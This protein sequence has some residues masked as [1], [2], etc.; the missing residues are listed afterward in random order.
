MKRIPYCFFY[1]V[2][3]LLISH[4][5]FAQDTVQVV[6]DWLRKN[7]LTIKYIEAGNNFS[8]LQSLKKTL[9]G[10]SVVGLGEATHGTREFFTMKHRLVEFLVKEMGFTAFALESSYSACQ[11]I[12]DYIL[13]GKGD[14]AKALTNQGYMPW[15]TEEFLAMLDWMRAYNQK[16]SDEEKVKF[17]GMDVLC[18]NGVGREKVRAYLAKYAPNRVAATDSLFHVLASEDEKWPSRLNQNALQSTFIPLH[19]LVGYFTA[20]KNKLVAASSLK[21]WE[22]TY[23]Y[24][25]VMEQGLYVN[26][27]DIPATLDSKKLT[28]DEYMAQNLLYFIEKERPNTKFIVWQHNGH[29]SKRSD[30]KQLGYNLYQAL[31][32]RYYAIAFECYEGTF[33]TRVELPDG[34]WGVLKSDTIHPVPK[35]LGW[36]LRRTGKKSL[37]LNLRSIASNSVVEKW[38]E[39]PI[40]F[41]N[42]HWVYRGPVKN[43][44]TK[45]IKDFYDGILYIERS[46]PVHPTKNALERSAGRIG[47]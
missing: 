31:G 10:V 34:F 22:Q 37:F 4:N 11:P 27:K 41:N 42:G 3:A 30:N 46:T 33:Q 38:L 8:D 18:C 5:S 19:E 39:T 2:I 7:S 15:D 9:Q 40:R 25:E 44:D 43:F 20:N 35:S 23:K 13:T 47:F 28:R 24:L 1:L 6:T 21:E 14:L 45:N 17:Y 29:I 32:D 12:N 36:Y 16:V 26:V